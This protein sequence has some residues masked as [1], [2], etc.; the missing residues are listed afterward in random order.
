MI[1]YCPKC[2]RETY[3]V[4]DKGDNIKVTQGSR[5]ILNISR[6]SNINLGLSCP[7]GH[8]VKLTIKS[9]EEDGSKKN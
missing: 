2:H 8:S 6:K 7:S 1:K 3:R 9:E 5:T 4:N